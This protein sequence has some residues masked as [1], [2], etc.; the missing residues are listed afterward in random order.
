MANTR[1]FERWR[2]ALVVAA[3]F[4]A[5]VVVLSPFFWAIYRTMAFNT[6]PRDDY[7]PF[8][9]WV[10]GRP[11]GAFPGSPYG[12]RILSAVAA[13][14]LYLLLPPLHLTN[15]PATTPIPYLR[16]TAA[17]ALLSYGSAIASGFLIAGFSRRCGLRMPEAGLAGAALFLLCW[18]SQIYGIDPFTILLVT[19]L[20]SLTRHPRIFAVLAVVSVIADEKACMVMVIW[21]TIRC[22]LDGRGWKEL[23][24]A[25]IASLGALAVYFLMIKLV[26]LPGNQYQLNPSGYLQTIGANLAVNLSGRGMVLNFVPTGILFLI[27]L[28]GWPTLP[29]WPFSRLDIL[30]IPALV[31]LALT[32]TEDFQIGR[33]VMHAA[34]L[35]VVPAA[36]AVGFWSVRVGSFVRGNLR[37][38]DRP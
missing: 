30:V 8:V 23:S 17:I 36:A 22:V 10:L 13:A 7:A 34:P 33:I 3:G 37:S 31:M 24:G 15:L 20:L 14:P 19:I 38:V 21:L 35:F 1:S 25:W 11:G 27:A 26:H 29:L 28:I 6:M 12:Y 16:A 32:V 18:H 9:L 4:L 2:A 5:C